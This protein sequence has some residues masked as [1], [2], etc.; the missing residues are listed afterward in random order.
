VLALCVGIAY[1]L[2]MQYTVRGIPAAL[3]KA[4]RQRARAR[5][6]SLN[7][8]AIETLAEGIGLHEALLERRDL[9]D[10][11]GTWRKDTAVEAALAAQDEV[12]E[13]LWK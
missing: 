8:I 11:I 13:H 5:G 9:S 2:C 7:E 4:M 1:T 3:D 10:I 12:D 6:K